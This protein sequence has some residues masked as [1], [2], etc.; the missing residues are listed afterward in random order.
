[1][2]EEVNVYVQCIQIFEIL[3][4]ILSAVLHL[5]MKSIF[6]FLMSL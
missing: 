2:N 5:F 4:K 3:Y 1:M 6:F